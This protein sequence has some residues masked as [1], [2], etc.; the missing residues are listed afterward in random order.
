MFTPKKTSL[1]V[2]GDADAGNT[3]A[4][5]QAHQQNVAEKYGEKNREEKI[6]QISQQK[7]NDTI[8]YFLS[9]VV[10]IFYSVRLRLRVC[11]RK[12]PAGLLVQRSCPKNPPFVILFEVERCG[13]A[14][15]SEVAGKNK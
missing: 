8:L 3:N 10:Q 15:R 7:K 6:K 2:A 14:T 11:A 9:F 13:A 1:P 5:I 12:R 4:H